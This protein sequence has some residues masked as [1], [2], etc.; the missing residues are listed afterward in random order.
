ML[1]QVLQ[2]PTEKGSKWLFKGFLRSNALTSSYTQV[3]YG[4]ATVT[5][6]GDGITIVSAPGR[7]GVHLS[8]TVNEGRLSGQ[9][10]VSSGDALYSG[11]ADGVFS[12]DQI[13]VSGQAQTT[14]GLLQANYQFLH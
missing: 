14:D 6:K 3:T 9:M 10:G 5:A 8:G 4:L 13:S 12:P 11:K 2:A 7:A 1:T